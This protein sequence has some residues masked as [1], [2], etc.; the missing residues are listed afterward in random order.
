MIIVQVGEEKGV[1]LQVSHVAGHQLPYRSVAAIHQI[2]LAVDDHGT[3][4][5]SACEIDC[6]TGAR[7]E[8]YQVGSGLCSPL[9]LLHGSGEA[10]AGALCMYGPRKPRRCECHG[11]QGQRVA[12]D[13]APRHCMRLSLGRIAL[14][15]SSPAP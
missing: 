5:L 13:A 14:E 2:R 15:S 10:A 8:K 4:G 9:R 11:S 1:D 12:Q 3:A 6:R 7:A